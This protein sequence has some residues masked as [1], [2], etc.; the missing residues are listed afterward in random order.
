MDP[1]HKTKNSVGKLC[2]FREGRLKAIVKIVNVK[3]KGDCTYTTLEILAFA[4][5]T[6]VP[7]FQIGRT[8]TVSENNRGTWNQIWLLTHL[9]AVNVPDAILESDP[10][11]KYQWKCEN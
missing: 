3:D 7:S 9:Q 1:F 10:K 4:F 6:Q 5:K 2:H 8:F 11:S